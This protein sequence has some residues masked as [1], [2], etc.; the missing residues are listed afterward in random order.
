MIGTN[1][2]LLFSVLLMGLGL[3]VAHGGVAIPNPFRCSTGKYLKQGEV[4][5]SG[6]GV[7]RTIRK[8]SL[9]KKRLEFGL[10][11]DNNLEEYALILYIKNLVTKEDEELKRWDLDSRGDLL[12]VN[13]YGALN[14]I[15]YNEGIIE[16][17]GCQAED[18]VNN[19]KLIM[20][21]SG[22]VLKVGK[23]VTWSY[24]RFDKDE[25]QG[26]CN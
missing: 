14:V 4:L 2:A 19:A 17:F 18:P 13:E 12:L 25:F 20:D 9:T 8:D 26:D 24:D 22:P 1:K 23:K 15:N 5:Y 3:Q 7:C 16:E 10:E 6:D 21:K 11:N